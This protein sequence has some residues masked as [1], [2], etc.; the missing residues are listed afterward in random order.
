MAAVLYTGYHV[1]PFYYY[2]YELKNHMFEAIRVASI[3]TDD[4]L[5]Q[6]LV[7]QIKWMEIP[8]DPQELVIERSDGYM[9]ISLSYDEVFYFT[10]QGKDYEIYTFHFDAEEEGDI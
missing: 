10:W 5:R 2:Y 4:E 9:R 8:A 1:L 3:Y 7:Y 6:K